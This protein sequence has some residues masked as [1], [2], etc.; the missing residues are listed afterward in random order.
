MSEIKQTM[1]RCRIVGTLLEKALEV[2]EGTARD[3][4][5]KEFAC[6]VI[7]GQISVETANGTFPLRVYCASKTKEKKDNRMYTGL[8]TIM[9]EYI[10][11][12][13]VSKDST[14]T[15][16]TIDCNVKMDINDYVSKNSGKVVTAVQMSM[17]SAKRVPSETE[18]ITDVALEG[19]IGKIVPETDRDE[20]ETGRLVVTFVT[21]GYG[22]KA[23]P[24]T[25]IVPE[26]IASDFEGMYEEGQTTVLY[27]SI[28]MRHVGSK[29]NTGAAF[30]KKAH[31]SSGFDIQ[32]IQV[33]GGE[34]A[35]EDE[36]DEEGNSKVISSSDIK[37]LMKE[38]KLYLEQLEKDGVKE[39]A[40]THKKTLSE[41]KV[42]IEDSTPF[43]D[44]DVDDI[45]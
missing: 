26:D 24:Y 31:V 32:E 39:S 21:I 5:G 11:R 3:V 4:N 44:V 41:R 14:K 1:N 42:N 10:S 17:N 33:I 25:L 40:P 18:S 36:E 28:V 9:N 8:K 45:F 12:L 13:D 15:A 22:E 6:D 7:Q 43:D 35:Y 20:N 29:Q 30:G 16:D 23:K 19:Y 2:K 38:R 37:N 27:C 34:S